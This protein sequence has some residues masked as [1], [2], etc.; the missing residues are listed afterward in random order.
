[1]RLPL[2][3]SLLLALAAFGL[4]ARLDRAFHALGPTDAGA[5]PVLTVLLGDSR[6]WVAQQIYSKADAYFHSGYYPS[7][8]D[9]KPEAQGNHLTASAEQGHA[10]QPHGPPEAPDSH[11]EETDI[12]GPPRDWIDRFSRNFFPSEHRH[13]GETPEEHAAHARGDPL[14]VGSNGHTEES[15]RDTRELL[16]WLRLSATLDPGRPETYV[17]ASFWLRSELG[18]VNEAEQFLRE[19]LR[20]NP[21]QPELLFELGR[22]YAE[23]RS[24]ADRARNIWEYALTRYQQAEASGT[25]PNPLLH[26]QILGNLARLEEKAGRPQ[27]AIGYLRQWLLFSPN[28]DALRRW[29]SQLEQGGASPTP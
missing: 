17:V 18:R 24:D 12:L 1:M 9:A 4:A 29:I 13:L 21:G 25:P 7:A 6:Q 8:F 14:Q 22:I 28:P 20:A 27:Q 11:E 15:G 3:L 19:G 16:P 26:A 2:L 23:N 10:G 5:G